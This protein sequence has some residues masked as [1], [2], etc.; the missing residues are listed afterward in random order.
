MSENPFQRLNSREI[1][2][3]R[4]I[5]LREDDVVRPG[6]ESGKFGVVT[7]RSG[8]SVLAI[9]KEKEVYLVKEYKYAAGRESIEVISG[10]IEDGEAPLAAAKRELLEEAGLQSERWLDLGSVDPFTTVIRSPNYLFLAL[11]VQEGIAKPDPGEVL[12][13]IKLP[14][15]KAMEMVMKG[16]ITHA[17]SCVLL[18]K[19]AIILNPE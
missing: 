13:R 6:G 9:N 15:P 1:Y 16:E 11:D 5:Q 17:A 3:N 19:A 12:E 4:W 2:A 14:F 7:M 8:S 10:A 18:L